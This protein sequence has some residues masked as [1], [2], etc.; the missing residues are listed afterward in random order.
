LIGLD[1]IE[2]SQSNDVLD[3]SKYPAQIPTLSGYHKTK[4]LIDFFVSAVAILILSPLYIL[5]SLL[6]LFD[7]GSPVIFWQQRIGQNGSTFF[8]Y[9]FRTL[10]APFD[11]EG[12]PVSEA[13]RLSWVGRLLRKTRL[14]ELP[15]LFNVLVGDMA[16]I[17]P[18]PLLPCDQ[19]ENSKLRLA[20]RPGITGWA[21]VN[22]GNLIT[23]DEKGALDDWYVRNASLW[24]DLRIIGLTF[25]FLFRGERRSEHALNH[26]V[27]EQQKATQPWRKSMHPRRSVRE[28]L[29][30]SLRRGFALRVRADNSPPPISPRLDQSDRNKDL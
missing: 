13:Q 26:A 30:T 12:Q 25:L 19:P 15:Q 27:I 20:A 7:V 11:W 3:L 17:G 22:G 14:D 4:R 8:L 23:N 2:P 10:R 1:K 28:V 9:K 5:F 16:L 24:I 29:G 6:I 21:Q 18:R